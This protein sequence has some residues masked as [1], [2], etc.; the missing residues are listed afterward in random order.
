[1]KSE[2]TNPIRFR[3]PRDQPF[4]KTNPIPRGSKLPDAVVTIP[5]V[6]ILLRKHRVTKN[7]LFT[8]RRSV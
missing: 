1:M 7:F 4:F 6:L 5:V 2:G 8:N 3:T